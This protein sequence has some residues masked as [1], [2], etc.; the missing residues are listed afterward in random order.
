V[1]IDPAH[2]TSPPPVGG[3]PTAAPRPARSRRTLALTVL[4]GLVAFAGVVAVVAT[5]SDDRRDEAAPIGFGDDEPPSESRP[6]DADPDEA[7]RRKDLEPSPRP[8]APA[9]SPTAPVPAQG[10]APTVP[11]PVP[12]TTVATTTP[13]PP[14]PPV[15][16]VGPGTY[17]CTSGEPALLVLQWTSLNAVSVTI[18]ID[19]PGGIY[20]PDLPVFGALEV[21]APCAPDSRTYYVIAKAADGT[22]QVASHTV[23]GI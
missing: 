4:A 6:V 18:S 10:P 2:T 14:P 13:P 22:T 5:A 11:V 8:S 21:P 19:Y 3:P 1:T 12:P 20:E 23:R 7:Q 16:V 15:S 17:A 9:P